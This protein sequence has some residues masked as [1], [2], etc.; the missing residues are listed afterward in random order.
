MSKV[1]VI[2]G[3]G[4]GLGRALAHRFA[5]DGESVVLLGR[6][7]SKVQ[8]VAAQIGGSAMAIECDVA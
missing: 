3:A 5:A 6:T 2:T 1:I 4:A 8:E 7:L